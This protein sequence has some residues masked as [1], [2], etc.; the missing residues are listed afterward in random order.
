VKD[1]LYS[2]IKDITTTEKHR[3]IEPTNV[4][5]IFYCKKSKKLKRI[6]TVL[7]CLLGFGQGEERTNRAKKNIAASFVIKGTN[8]AVGLILV[9]ITIN[10]LN[11][12][13]YGIWIT[14]TSLVAWFGFFD[15]GLGNGL[16]NKFAEAIANNN[17]KLARTYVSTT[18]AILIIIICIILVLFYCI[19]FFLNW[20]VILNAGNDLSLKKEL[21]YLA[22]VV[23]TSFGMTFVLNLISVILSADQQP[24]KGALFDLIGKSLALLFIYTL[25]KVHKSSLLSLG[26]VY[27][28]ISPFILAISTV[29]F[30]NTKYSSYR[31]GLKFVDFSKAKDLFN[32]G[33]KFFVL[34]ISSIVLY[35][36]N[37]IIISQLLGPDKVTPYNVAFKYFSVLLMGF[38]IIVSPF[39]SAFTEAWTKQDLAWIDNIMKKLMKLW[40]LVAAG[41]IFMLMISEFIYKFWIG[42]NFT[43]PFSISLL[44]LTWIL[45]ITWNAIFCQFLNGVGKIKIQLIIGVLAAIINIPLAIFL[46]HLMGINGI[47]ISN[48]L[49]SILTVFIYPMQYQKLINGTA[50]GLFNS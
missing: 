24:A 8:I 29:W 31:P 2:F 13:N 50:R 23:F 37:N 5:Y 16:R 30:F 11:R 25:T 38:S 41:G 21:N 22:I 36:T 40:L 43:V 15:I 39:W 48:I 10:Y 26:L 42:N 7:K 47:L 45:T 20:N 4:N 12:A 28:F 35:Q 14:L 3:P 32:L 46:G 18:Y 44:S 19:N 34:Q 49:L 27:C 9:S 33:V 17:H 1:Y 6:I